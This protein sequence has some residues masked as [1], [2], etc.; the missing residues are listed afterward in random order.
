M[1]MRDERIA[2]LQAD[3][4]RLRYSVGEGQWDFAQ[5]SLARIQAE[6]IALVRADAYGKGYEAGAVR[7]KVAA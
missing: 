5:S 6:M 7:Q 1:T 4:D 3:I 2:A